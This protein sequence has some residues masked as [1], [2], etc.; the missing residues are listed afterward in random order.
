MDEAKREEIKKE[1]KEILDKF[2]HMIEAVKLKTRGEKHELGGFREE[3]EGKICD[4]DFRARMF[5]NFRNKDI[6]DSD[7]E[8]NNLQDSRHAPEKDEDYIY[9]EKKIW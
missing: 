8:S 1:A 5:A 9:A 7:R 6:S 2:S 4:A 3:E